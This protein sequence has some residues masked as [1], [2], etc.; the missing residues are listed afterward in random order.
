MELDCRQ[1]RVQ[2]DIRYDKVIQL[3]LRQREARDTTTTT[4]K[5]RGKEVAARK[6]RITNLT[7]RRLREFRIKGCWFK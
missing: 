7:A 3:N 6:R 1:H 4:I 5:V 2:N